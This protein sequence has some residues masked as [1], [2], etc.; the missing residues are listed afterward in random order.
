MK[1]GKTIKE[2]GTDNVKTPESCFAVIENGKGYRKNWCD[3]LKTKDPDLFLIKDNLKPFQQ[4]ING[5]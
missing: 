4:E 2:H 5:N 3:L 1:K